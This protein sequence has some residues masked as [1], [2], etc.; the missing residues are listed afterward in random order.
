MTENTTQPMDSPQP[1]GPAQANAPV[2]PGGQPQRV[3]AAAMKRRSGIFRVVN[4][5]MRAVLSLPFPTPLSRNLML[6]R[7]TGRKSGRVY[8]QPLSYARDGE[9]L[10]TPGGGRWTLN[11]EGGRP[12]RIRLRGRDVPAR[13]ELVRE[14][15]EV[16]RLLD[17][18]VR[19][20]PP[21]ARYIPLPRQAD[22][23]LEPTAL[24]AAIDHGFAIVRWNLT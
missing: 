3:D 21:A 6:V 14:P 15:G 8:R 4:V 2:Q 16:E 10:L 1:N 5:P 17:V 20:N 13:P 11:M 9:A 24:A 12:V 22:G 19:E 18:I 7:Y 23:R